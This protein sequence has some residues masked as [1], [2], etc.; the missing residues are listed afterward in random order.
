MYD[1]DNEFRKDIRQDKAYKIMRSFILSEFS[2]GEI[3]SLDDVLRRYYG[4][5]PQQATH[6]E[7]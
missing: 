3:L 6:E 2:K 1:Y 4:K 5:H 7:R